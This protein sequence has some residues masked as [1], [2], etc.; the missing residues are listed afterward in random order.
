M[1]GVQTERVLLHRN[2][3]YGGKEQRTLKQNKEALR[4]YS[5]WKQKQKK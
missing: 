3:T 4:E 2:K 5:K 1:V